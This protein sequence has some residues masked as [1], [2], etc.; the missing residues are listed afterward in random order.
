MAELRFELQSDSE[1]N[2]LLCTTC[3]L[4]DHVVGGMESSRREVKVLFNWAAQNLL[5]EE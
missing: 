2:T 1:A 5:S 4:L 3:C